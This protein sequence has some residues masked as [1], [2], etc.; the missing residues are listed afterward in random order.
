MLDLVIEA[1]LERHLHDSLV[2]QR[3]GPPEKS[4]S[5]LL[6]HDLLADFEGAPLEDSLGSKI[7]HVLGLLDYAASLQRPCSRPCTPSHRPIEKE[8]A[9]D[10]F[11]SWLDFLQT[12]LFPL[13]LDF[14]LRH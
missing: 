9:V 10:V 5:P 3:H 6:H 1:N 13:A 2:D 4:P 14:L 7:A 12:L 8:L 11:F